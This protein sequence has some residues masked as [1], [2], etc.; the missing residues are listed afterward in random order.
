MENQPLKLAHLSS[1]LLSTPTPPLHDSKINTTNTNKSSTK[2]SSQI[3]K[4]ATSTPTTKT[5]P[6]SSKHFIWSNTSRSY[7][8]HVRQD[9]M[10]FRHNTNTQKYEEWSNNVFQAIENGPT[11][12]RAWRYKR[13]YKKCTW[14]GTKALTQASWWTGVYEIKLYNPSKCRRDLSWAYVIVVVVVAGI[15]SLQPLYQLRYASVNWCH[16]I[17]GIDQQIYLYS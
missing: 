4:L 14:K 7:Q 1:L 17:K 3:I 13:I 12:E 10:G 6:S 16:N 2:Q 15:R 9:Q 8:L 11:K 5:Y